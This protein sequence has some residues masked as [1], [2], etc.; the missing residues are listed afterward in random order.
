MFMWTIFN[1]LWVFVEKMVSKMQHF[2]NLKKQAMFWNVEY[3]EVRKKCK[4]PSQILLFWESKVEHHNK[5]RLVDD[6]HP[7]LASDKPTGTFA[8]LPNL[9]ADL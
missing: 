6:R 5:H 4:K 1:L 7:F 8:D 9:E 3:D 2:Q